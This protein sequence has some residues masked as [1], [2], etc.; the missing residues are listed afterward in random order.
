MLVIQNLYKQFGSL[1][2]VNEFNLRVKTGETVVLMGPSGCGKS[3]AI[4]TINRLVEP[5]RGSIMLNDSNILAMD[6]DELRQARKRIG[7]VFQHF[8]LIGRLSALENVM[9]GLVMSGAEREN[10][11]SRATES[12]RKVGLDNHLDHKPDQ[13]S[14]GQ[15]QRVGIAR[16]LAYEPELMLWDEPTA[17]LDPILVRE[18][19][20]VMEELARYRAS[21]MIVVTHELPFALRVADRIILMD[22]GSIVEEG[23]PSQV[24]VSPVSDIGKKYKELIEY[25]MNTSAQS[26]AGKP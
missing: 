26:L 18:V 12:L 20:V 25:Q 24:F 22:H 23:K 10:A 11:E 14:G 15:Q 1:V 21:T 3:T 17:S 2:A 16:A 19:L 7:F 6:P 8:N 4:R 9:L 13:L 5:D